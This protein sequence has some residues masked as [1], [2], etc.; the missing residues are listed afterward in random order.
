MAKDSLLDNV[1]EGTVIGSFTSFGY[2]LRSR[3]WDEIDLQSIAGKTV[4]ITGATSGIGRKVATELASA[5]AR[6]RF[7]ARNPRKAED[8]KRE[9]L[10][11][12]DQANVDYFLAD[13]SEVANVRRVAAEIL[14]AEPTI[15]LL[16]NNA[17]VLPATR[18]LTPEGLEMAHATNLVAPFVLTNALIPRLIESQPA[19]IINVISGGMYAQG[20]ELDDPHFEEG[21]YRGSIA[22]ARAKR[23]LM[24][25]T[26]MW[27]ARLADSEVTVH[28]THPGWVD[29]PGVAS[30]IPTFHRVMG[31]WL[32]NSD[33]GADTI[34]WLATADRPT[35]SPGKLWHDR[36]VR[37]EYRFGIGIETEADREQLWNLL[38]EHAALR[39]TSRL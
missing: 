37:P 10:D 8:L 21:P 19:R 32:R 7:I 33:Q 20:L 6:L 18:M 14:A 31:P 35:T 1:L 34:L 12:T 23:G 16:I 22:Y 30:S 28:A 36:T 29:T 26:K 3:S 9:L 2:K 38:E 11:L 39:S 4:V 25:L 15:H 27:A 5:G 17:V 24:V 13:L